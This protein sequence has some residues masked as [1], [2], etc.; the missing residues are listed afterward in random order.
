MTAPAGA[1]SARVFAC[2]LFCCLASP[3][4]HA[5]GAPAS[6]PGYPAKPLRFILPVAA[7]S[8]SDGIARLVCRAL[9]QRL[10]Q[11]ILAENQ[12]GAGGNVGVPMAARAAADGYTL[13]L[14]SSAQAIS[15]SV[16]AQLSYDLERDFQPV[17]QIADGLYMLAV[18]P[19]IPARSVRALVA[20]AKARSGQLS[21]GSAGIGTGTHLTGE[22]LKSAAGIDLLHVPY[23]GMGPAIAELAGG[24][25]SMAFLGLP[26]GLPQVQA[27]KLRALG[28]TSAQRSP[29]VP[30]L[31]T[32]AEAG[33]PGFESTTWQ[34][35]VVPAQT[36]R[37]IV[38]RLHADIVRAL[39]SS[40]V[41]EKF[42]LLGVEAVGNTPEQFARR[43]RAEIL[44]WSRLVRA[45]GLPRQ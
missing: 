17:S 31:P 9:G 1:G 39:Q 20:L 45:I 12:P 33:L 26:S 29:A 40:E 2:A 4:A 15:P 37:D 34:G 21:Y 30:D 13:L 27:K 38:G 10:G 23:R 3:A 24:Q 32:L 41:R 8:T 42:A 16:Y 35:I 7:G 11:Q 28:V 18:H 43:I 19:S 44:K 25:I 22:L 14:I 6:S 5:Q 36:P